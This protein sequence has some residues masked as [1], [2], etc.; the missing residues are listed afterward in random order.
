MW[1]SCSDYKLQAD[2]ILV[3]FLTVYTNITK[4]IIYYGGQK[5]LRD[6]ELKNIT[7]TIKLH[8]VS[9][10]SPARWTVFL[11]FCIFITLL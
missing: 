10:F 4:K 3:L 9:S 2:L 11:N 5:S 6:T 8:V 1:R 7:K